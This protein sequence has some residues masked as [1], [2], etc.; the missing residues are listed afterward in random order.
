MQEQNLRDVINFWKTSESM[1]SVA[2]LLCTRDIVR[3]MLKQAVTLE[4]DVGHFRF[5]KIDYNDSYSFMRVTHQPKFLKAM[6]AAMR[7]E[8]FSPTHPSLMIH[9]YGRVLAELWGAAPNITMNF[10]QLPESFMGDDDIKSFSPD[11]TV[12]EAFTRSED[13]YLQGLFAG[14]SD[15]HSEL[16][17][18]LK[19]M[20]MCFLQCEDSTFD[21]SSFIESIEEWMYRQMSFSLINTS[22]IELLQC[23][24][25]NVKSLQGLFSSIDEKLYCG[26][27]FN[28]DIDASAV[29]KQVR[30]FRERITLMPAQNALWVT[31][32]V[33]SMLSIDLKPA[34]L[35]EALSSFEDDINLFMREHLLLGKSIECMEGSLKKGGGS[36]STRAAMSDVL[37][38]K[39]QGFLSLFNT[40]LSLFSSHCSRKEVLKKLDSE[41]V[42]FRLKV[43][44]IEQK[45]MKEEEENRKLKC[46]ALEFE[47]D[48]LVARVRSFNMHN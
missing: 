40:G 20:I 11:V 25:V 6:Q 26:E 32:F 23:I 38:T 12:F 29:A 43:A 42:D 21:F 19:R 39:T 16:F 5:E 15:L 22:D 17:E 47:A 30:Q 46:R 3:L 35:P 36:G 44:G 45:L 10:G 18:P 28:A 14:I 31:S 37:K 41:V 2:R 1:N 8:S 33:A 9:S 13:L 7:E 27:R 24:K 48:T 4:V 34:V